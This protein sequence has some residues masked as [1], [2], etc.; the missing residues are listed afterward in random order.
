M[1]TIHGVEWVHS[2]TRGQG[3]VVG[4]FRHSEKFGTIVLLIITIPAEILFYEG[5]DSLGLTIG[6]GVKA[7]GQFLLSSSE[8][9][10]GSG[11]FG[12]ELDSPI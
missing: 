8:A 5:I 6:L 4:K 12:G 3:V 1:F 7:G 10:E 9:A 11:E 2:G